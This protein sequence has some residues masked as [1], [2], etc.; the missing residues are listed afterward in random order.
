MNLIGRLQLS[1]EK[2]SEEDSEA[3]VQLRI[4]RV[5]V[6]RYYLSP[7][8]LLLQCDWATVRYSLISKL[9]EGVALQMK[10]CFRR[11]PF[12]TL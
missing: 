4:L 2:T 6:L 3:I 7:V 10:I 5:Q 11:L 1:T 9:K 12:Q 8:A